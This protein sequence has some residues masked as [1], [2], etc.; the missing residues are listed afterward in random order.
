MKPVEINHFS[1]IDEAAL[2]S[3]CAMVAERL[4]GASAE[5]RERVLEALQVTV[6]AT[7]EEAIVEG[8]L[9]IEPSDFLIK[10]W[11]L[12]P[13]NKHRHDDVHEA[14]VADGAEDAG[15]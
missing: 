15:G 9:P 14:V 12:S 6:T 7:R 4:D 11:V 13:L 1:T 10:E 8:V 3:A 5:D 2:R